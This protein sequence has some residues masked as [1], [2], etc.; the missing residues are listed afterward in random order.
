MAAPGNFAA[1]VRASRACLTFRL[2]FAL[3]CAAAVPAAQAATDEPDGFELILLDGYEDCGLAYRDLDA[4]TYGGDSDVRIQ[5]PPLPAGYVALG[6][7]CNDANPLINPG[8]AETAPDAQFLDENCDGVDGNVALALFVAPG[9]SNAANCG[10]RDLPCSIVVAP[11]RAL[12]LGRTQLYLRA[13][14]HAGMPPL[15]GFNGGLAFHGG[16]DANWVRA[17][18]AVNLSRIDGGFVA[19]VG[20]VGA[21][22]A[23]GNYVLNELEVAAPSAATTLPGGIGATSY[24]VRVLSGAALSITRS[25]ISAGAGFP[26][27]NGSNGS[28]ASQSAAPTGGTGGAGEQFLTVCNDSSRGSRGSAGINA[29]PG[30]R[31]ASGGQ[32]GL[33]GTMD[34]S[35]SGLGG[36]CFG[37]DCNATS[38]TNGLNAAFVSG[39]FGTGGAAGV[40]CAGSSGADPGIVTDGSAG[41]GGP[42]SRGQLLLAPPRW[43]GFAGSGGTLGDNGGGGGGGGGAGGCDTGTDSYGDGGGGGGAGGCRAPIAGGGGN[44]GGGSIAVFAVQALSLSISNSTIVALGGADGGFG[45]NGGTGQ[46]PGTGGP[47]GSGPGGADGGNGANGGRGGHAGGGG[48][49]AG[50]VSVGVF[51]FQVTP[52]ISNVAPQI[53]PPGQGGSGGGGPVGGQSGANGASSTVLTCVAAAGC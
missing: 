45:G 8:V 6:G 28:N 30:G 17:P 38:G 29:C 3:S 49:G 46:P 2:G 13:G 34:A 53:A 26:G 5:C 15:S 14:N 12:T 24:G 52:A 9:G 27:G 47:G 11:S 36:T 44:P 18:R 1:S 32:G 41:A 19:Q 48:G 23:N 40:P 31:S 10:M 21:E 16:Y 4:D 33:G 43:Q 51:A 37:S 42:N 22:F 25:T 7:D 50:G 20:T 35:C 39:P